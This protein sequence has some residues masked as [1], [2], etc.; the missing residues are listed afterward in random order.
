MELNTRL[1]ILRDAGQISKE[2]YEAMLD[3]INMFDSKW[4]IKLTEENGAMF[5]THLT[6]AFQRIVSDETIDGLN[7]NAYR[8]IRENAN[9]GKC[10]EAL[11]DVERKIGLK[12]PENE[13]S[14]LMLYLCTLFESA[15]M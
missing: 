4:G 8:E 9:Y 14:F 10:K 12:I 7:E 1:Q 11:K 15:E 2:N 6:V 3:V 13:E 5:I